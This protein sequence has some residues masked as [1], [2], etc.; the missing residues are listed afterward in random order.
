MCF[1]GVALS[2]GMRISSGR[3]ELN[4]GGERR[5]EEGRVMLRSREAPN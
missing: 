3:K 1:S 2:W 5:V 4:T